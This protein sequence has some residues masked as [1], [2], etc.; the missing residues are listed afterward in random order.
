MCSPN[1]FG[2]S[3]G[4]FIFFPKF[5]LG[6]PWFQKFQNFKKECLIATLLKWVLFTPYLTSSY[7]LTRWGLWFAL[8]RNLTNLIPTPVGS[9]GLSLE[10]ARALKWDKYVFTFS[11]ECKYRKDHKCTQGEGWRYGKGKQTGPKRNYLDYLLIKSN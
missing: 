11:Y 5:L 4:A 2:E 9:F 3:L 7:P 1:F 10:W 8:P 6:C